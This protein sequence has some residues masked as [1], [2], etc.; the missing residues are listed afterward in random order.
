MLAFGRSVL[1]HE[2]LSP[3]NTRRWLKP[4]SATSASNLLLGT[5]WEIYRFVNETKDGRLIELY[6]K[7]GNLM[8]YNSNFVLIP[9]YD[10]VLQVFTAGNE[11]SGGTVLGVTTAAMRLLLPAL[12]EAGKDEA[13]ISHAGTYTDT[14]S[15]SSITLSLDDDGPGIRVS[16]WTVRGLDVFDTLPVISTAFTSGPKLETKVRM[17]MYPTGLETDKQSSW[18]GVFTF[19]TAEELAAA[20]SLFMWPMATCNT[21]ALMD[22]TQYGLQAMDHFIFTQEE[23]DNGETAVSV[24]LPAYRIVLRKTPPVVNLGEDD[25]QKPLTG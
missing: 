25:H 15:N 5:P 20:E 21:W 12:E 10:I 24:E 2:Q 4:V 11:T 1:K 3:V 14:A 16:N 23:G 8:D 22:R 6:T 13:R 19:G 17:R 18:R 7:M 9:D